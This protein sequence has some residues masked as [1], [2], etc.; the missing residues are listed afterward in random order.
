MAAEGASTATPTKE[1]ISLYLYIASLYFITVGVLYLWGYWSSFGIDILPYVNLTDVVRLTLY[2]IASTFVFFMTGVLV[3][4]ISGSRHIL[5]PGGGRDTPVGRVLNRILPL[6]SAVYA[7][8]LFVI[9]LYGG[10]AKWMVLPGLIAM[11][12]SVAEQRHGVF[13]SLWPNEAGR[14]TVV[15]LLA[16]LPT[17]AYGQGRLKAAAI[18]DGGD[19]YYLAANTIDSVPIG[20]VRDPKGHVKYLGQVNDYIFLLLPDNSTSVI[21]R[22]DKTRGLQVKRYRDAQK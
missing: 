10:P 15:F 3:S 19:Y 9:W 14:M 11:P 1:R 5:P 6:L 2:P 21:V 22:F 20:D 18:L 13:R 8:I 12:M 4:H 16:A 17:W 7:V